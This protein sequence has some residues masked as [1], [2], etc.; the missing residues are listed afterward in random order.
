MKAWLARPSAH[1]IS[2]ATVALGV[3]LIHLGAVALAGPAPAA[4]ATSGAIFASLADQPG[5][6][7]RAWRR[8]VATGLIGIASALLV[9][10]LAAHPVALGMAIAVL[11]FGSTL[12]LAWGPRA[13][14]MSF[15]PVL[16]MVF[17]MALPHDTPPLPWLAAHLA[18]AAAYLAWAL[19]CLGLLRRRYATLALAN[20][21]QAMAELLRRRAALLA[22]TTED[23]DAFQRAWVVQEGVLAERLQAARDQVF[24]ASDDA[25]SRREAALLLRLIDLRDLL[26]AG[27]L[28]LDRI[29]DDPAGPAWRAWLAQALQQLAAQLQASREALRGVHPEL[30]SAEAVAP[31]PP[32]PTEGALTVLGPALQGRVTLLG[33]ESRRIGELAAGGAEEDLPLARAELRRFVAPEQ[34]PLASLRAQFTLA[35][36]VLRHALR[37]ALALGGAYALALAL[38]WAS[39]PQWLVLSVAVVLRGNL[40]QT[41]AR[42]NQRVGG[43]LLGCLLVLALAWRP[44][45][46]LMTVMFLAAVGIAHG[47]ALERYLLTAVAATVMSLLQAHLAQPALG[48]PVAE[49]LADTLLGALLAWGFSFVLPSWE[50]RALPRHL[51]RA[52]TALRDYA[53]HAL[54]DPPEDSSAQRIAR[55]QAYEALGAIGVALQRAAAEPARV[56]PPLA[57]LTRFLD[58]AQRL[59]ALLSM[60]RLVRSRGR[61]EA[62]DP[63]LQAALR[64]AEAALQQGLD[65]K[66]AV[67]PGPPPRPPASLPEADPLPW[68]LWRLQLAGRVAAQ[69]G[70]AARDLHRALKQA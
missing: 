49:R 46:P 6:P 8:I 21:L 10:L 55:R 16:A 7:A 29:A 13:G 61:V 57:E 34:W 33:V 64:D 32:V 58:L 52:G 4:W 62:S 45:T 66:A 35:S 27:L 41:L 25:R 1:V 60:I 67:E 30:S 11:A 56:R 5:T 39:H 44:S 37:A 26:L 31:P 22:A 23:G 43:T 3:A 15:V 42:R 9:L 50:R 18:G 69:T 40:E 12:T 48:F 24:S 38:P 63:A 2:G 19:L 59:M 14:P 17:T 47:F 65:P 20:A 28:D 36:P 53:R 70:L 51:S 54:A 68:L